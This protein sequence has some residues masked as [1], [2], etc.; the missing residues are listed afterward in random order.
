MPSTT[1]TYKRNQTRK[2]TLNKEYVKQ[3]RMYYSITLNMMSTLMYRMIPRLTLWYWKLDVLAI[4]MKALVAVVLCSAVSSHII[5]LQEGVK[6]IL[7]EIHCVML[8]CIR[9]SIRYPIHFGQGYKGRPDGRA[10]KGSVLTFPS[11]IKWA[12]YTKSWW[13][14]WNLSWRCHLSLLTKEHR[15]QG[16]W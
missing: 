13:S 9:L 3:A 7:K 6:A 12:I 2:A 10:A 5:Q 1:T 15:F 16:V 4:F 8:N 14:T 11:A